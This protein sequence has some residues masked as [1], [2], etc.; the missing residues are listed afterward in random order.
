[1]ETQIY[2]KWP[3]RIDGLGF[4]PNGDN[5]EILESVKEVHCDGDAIDHTGRFTVKSHRVVLRPWSL[6]PRISDGAHI[7]FTYTKATQ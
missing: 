1:M 7:V 4:H 6:F 5:V 3:P 2:H